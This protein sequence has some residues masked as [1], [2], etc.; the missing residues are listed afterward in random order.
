MAEK[1]DPEEVHQIMDGCFEVLMDEIHKHEGTINQFTGDGVMAIF[2]APVAHEDHSQRACHAALSIQRAMME[3]E[4]SVTRKFGTDFKMRI[5]LNSGPVVVGSIGDDLRMDYTAVGNTT[6]LASRMQSMA[7]PGA[8]L[9]SGETH[10]LTRDFFEFVSRGKMKVKGREEPIETY[11]LAKTSEFKT[12]IE[13]AATK[14]LTRFVGRKDSMT[15]LME[16]WENSKSGSGQVVGIVGEAGVGKSRLLLELKNRLPQDG[17]TYLE[18]RCIHYG[19]SMAYLPV[20]DVLRSYFKIQEGDQELLITRKMKEKIL[21]IDKGLTVHLPS[22]QDLFS[23]KVEDDVYVQLQPG[24]KRLRTFEAIRDLLIRESQSMPFVVTVEDLHWIDK[25]SED[26]LGYLIDWLPNT[27]ILLVLL[28]R[29]EY[30]HQ[31]GSKSYYTKVGLNQLGAA[32]SAELVRAILAEGEIAPELEELILSRASG[33]PLFMEEFTLGLLENGSIQKK[34]RQ[35]VLSSKASNIQVPDTIQGLIAARMDRLEDNLKRTMQVA[36]VIGREFAFRI[37]KTITG[38]REEIKTYLLNLQ[39]LEFIVEKSLF[40]ELEYIFKHALTQQVAYNSLLLARRKEIHDKI[41]QAIETLYPKRLEEFY[42]MLA[43]HYGRSENRIKGLEYLDLANHKAIKASAMQEAKAYFD[44]AMEVTDALPESDENCNRRLTLLTRQ[45]IVFHL[46]LKIPEYHDLLK[47]YKPLTQRLGN[48]GLVGAF[49][50]RLGACEFLLG[51][52]DQAIQT[53]TKA[54]ELCEAAKNAEEAGFAYG[55]LQWTYLFKGEYDRVLSLHEVFLRKMGEQFNLQLYT[56]VM[57]A[58]VFAYSDLGRWDEAVQ[59]GQEALRVAKEFSDSSQISFC[60]FALS[61]AYTSKGDLE[62]AIEHGELA[63]Q[64]A[65]T[66]ADKAWGQA[67]LARAKCRAGDPSSAIEFLSV[68]VQV[69]RS[70]R[71]MPNELRGGLSLGETLEELLKTAERCGAK[72]HIGG[73]HSLLGEIALKTDLAQAA[74]HFEKSISLYQEI[75][76]ENA[77]AKAYEGYGLFHIQNGNTTQAR[78]YLTKALE[79][80]ERLGTLIEPEEV[81]ELLAG[82]PEA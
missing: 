62:Q 60:A 26:F 79:I 38:M 31:W 33:N 16:A 3:Y 73:A 68:Y 80:F 18:G 74:S 17:F 15:A 22:L 32:S 56:R 52:F 72:L 29:P 59:E 71:Y 27:R 41:G 35:Y 76:A 47:R 42:E 55:C 4:E 20:L 24:E 39:G 11:E 10:K 43:Y 46:M 44:Q 49:Y 9:A 57:V 70:S 45:E 58:T 14:G 28:Y 13:A 48:S 40:P 37:L 1:L 2:G 8:I 66:P 53:L 50:G 34:D 12:R 64:K 30:T 51:D 36:S 82:L 25:T 63:V 19:L 78:E 23:L 21:R 69:S 75:M 7:R 6:N 77:L 61:Y 81:R 54:V 65:V 67:G 5:G